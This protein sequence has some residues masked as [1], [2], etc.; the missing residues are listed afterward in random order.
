MA[1]TSST[2]ILEAWLNRMCADL[3]RRYAPL[4]LRAS[5][6]ELPFVSLVCWLEFVP[7]A[8]LF[9][10]MSEEGTCVLIS[11]SFKILRNC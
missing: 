8:L 4:A 7:T 3:S 9:C 6:Q 11:G 5:L 2:L 1:V 10:R